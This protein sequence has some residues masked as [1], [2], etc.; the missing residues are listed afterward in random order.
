MCIFT[1][2]LFLGGYLLMNNLDIS[3]FL[4]KI[5]LNFFYISE[6]D[7]MF[8]LRCKLLIILIYLYREYF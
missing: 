3:N 6:T 2:I 5:I 8:I 7:S 1:S 4:F